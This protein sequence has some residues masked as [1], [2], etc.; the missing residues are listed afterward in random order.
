VTAATMFAT[1]MSTL[2]MRL[3]LSV[4]LWL[5]L[6]MLLFMLLLL[7]LR[8]PLLLSLCMLLLLILSMFL[9]CSIRMNARLL[10]RVLTTLL[11][12]AAV[13]LYG[14]VI[15][16]RCPGRCILRMAAVHGSEI[17]PVRMCHL[18][19]VLLLTG[20]RDMVLPRER[21]LLHRRACLDAAVPAVEAR[22]VI[23]RRMVDHG[24]VFVNIVPNP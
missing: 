1:T 9:W 23:N 7:V 22:A 8:V 17:T 4:L 3:S 12:D 11:S 24:P 5:S 10:G 13:L 21:S 14:R 18:H 2:S 20:R 16:T 6:R 19:M 15:L